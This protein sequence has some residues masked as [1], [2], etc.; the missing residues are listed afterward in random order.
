MFKIAKLYEQRSNLI[1]K[2]SA[3]LLVSVV[4]ATTYDTPGLVVLL[5]PKR[6]L[7]LLQV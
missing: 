5:S 1:Q 6:E 2:T 3:G 7:T 4:F